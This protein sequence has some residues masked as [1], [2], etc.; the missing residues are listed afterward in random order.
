MS[1]SSETTNQV[2]T[3]QWIQSFLSNGSQ[4]VVI[5]GKSSSPA[6]VTSGV[7][8][9]TVLGPLLFLTYNNDLLSRVKAKARLFPDD[10]LLYR[11]IKTDQDAASL[12]DDLNNLQEWEK[13]SQMHFNPDKCVVIRITNERRIIDAKYTIHDILSNLTK[14]AKYLGFTITNTLSWNMH[15]DTITKKV[16]NTTDFLRRNLSTC[17]KA[18]KDTIHL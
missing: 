2:G 11:N 12:Q 8:Q 17:P 3:L 16:N 18:V 14:K 7:P 5:E 6:P 10:C 13:D 9:G 1:S 4:K 15:S